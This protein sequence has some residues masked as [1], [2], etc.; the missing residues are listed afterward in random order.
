MGGA[1]RENKCEMLFS[2]VSEGEVEAQEAG[3]PLQSMANSSGPKNGQ[4]GDGAPSAA[5]SPMTS[6]DGLQPDASSWPPVSEPSTTLQIPSF[7]KTDPCESRG[8]PM[9]YRER[10]R[11]VVCEKRDPVNLVT[12]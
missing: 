9:S 2:R 8:V 5:L 10:T 1:A 4:D 3:E 6:D 12:A 7:A 11:E